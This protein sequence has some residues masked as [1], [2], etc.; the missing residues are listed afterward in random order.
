MP[1]HASHDPDMV[2]MGWEPVAFFG[3]NM[4][5]RGD[6]KIHVGPGIDTPFCQPHLT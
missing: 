6:E 4:N 5:E 2:K 1:F 3:G